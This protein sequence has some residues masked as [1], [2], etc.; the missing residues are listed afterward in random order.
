MTIGHT[1]TLLGLRKLIKLHRTFLDIA[2]FEPI[3]EKLLIV[4]SQD[5]MSSFSCL[6]EVVKAFV[7]RYKIPNTFLIGVATCYNIKRCYNCHFTIGCI[8]SRPSFEFKKHLY[9]SKLPGE[10]PN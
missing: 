2:L 4:H 5:V 1:I 6:Q 9:R 10:W 7:I 3:N 8:S